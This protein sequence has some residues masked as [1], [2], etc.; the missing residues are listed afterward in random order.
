MS[1]KTISKYDDGQ[2]GS[3]IF[4]ML[5]EVFQDLDGYCSGN[6]AIFRDRK[7]PDSRDTC[8][9][10]VKMLTPISIKLKQDHDYNPCSYQWLEFQ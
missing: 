1:L 3:V 4:A 7:P 5:E 10:K 8:N 9:I 2:L 6:I